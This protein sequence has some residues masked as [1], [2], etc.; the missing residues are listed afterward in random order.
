MAKVKLYCPKCSSEGMSKW[1]KTTNIGAVKQNYKCKNPSCAKRTTSPLKSEPSEITPMRK[2]LPKV[3][4]YI[5]TAAQNATPIH[6]DLWKS[7]KHCAEHYDAELVVIPGRYKN[8][9]SQWTEHNEHQEWWDKDVMPHLTHGTINLGSRLVILGDVKVQ[10]AAMNPLTSLETL[11][12]DKSGIVGHAR[13]ALKSVATPQHHHAKIMF[14]TG[15]VTQP[16]YTDT[17]QGSIAKF[18][19]AYGALIVEVADDRFHVRQLS[20]MRKGSFCDLDKEFT[21]E[22]VQDA[23]RPLSLTMGDT[24]WAK[25]D[26]DVYHAT[27]KDM[28]PSLKPHYLIWHDLLDQYARN[29]HHKNNYLL[30]YRKH[31]LKQDDI[32]AEVY[33]ALDA[34]EM[35]TPHDSQSI[36][37]SSNHDR[38]LHRWLLEAKI[39]EDPVNL[40]FHNELMSEVLKHYRENNYEDVDP[41]ILLGRKEL[42]NFKNIRFLGGDESFMLNGVEHCLHGDKGPNGSRGSTRNLSRIGVKV[43]KGHSHTAEIIDGCY[44]TGKSTGRLEYES[45]PS[46]HSN[47]HCLQYH[48]GKRTLITIINGKYK[49]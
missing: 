22:G 49:L 13:L 35:E 27:F 6:K 31:K 10:W 24:H 46:S 28:L 36:V 7:L 3:K 33:A 15:C 14:T 4:R 29:H 37:V 40:E 43:T 25:I 42:A 38:A 23:P 17:K 26:P 34:L 44:S 48:N 41:F 9:T 45:G 20:A 12:G 30:E 1:G 5:I 11:T 32:R 8:P 47:T 39:K 19:H 18:N 2:S 21:P 16:N